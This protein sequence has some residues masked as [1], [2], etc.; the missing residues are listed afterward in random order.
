MGAYQFSSLAYAAQGS[1]KPFAIHPAPHA[2]IQYR[3]TY[4]VPQVHGHY[5]EKTVQTSL[6]K[7]S[8]KL[9]DAELLEPLAKAITQLPV[10]KVAEICGSTETTVKNWRA[11]RNEP[12]LCKALRLGMKVESVKLAI[13]EIIGMHDAEPHRLILWLLAE[14]TDIAAH[15]DT[16]SAFKAR[17]VIEQFRTHAPGIAFPAAKFGGGQ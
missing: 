13:A 16:L 11:R 14:L 17:K 8:K 5:E 9:T 4:A 12:G 3:D 15:G 2:D 7:K 6:P 1:P 10:C